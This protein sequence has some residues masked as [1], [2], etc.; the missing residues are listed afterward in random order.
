MTT[1]FKILNVLLPIF[2]FELID[3]LSILYVTLIMV[4]FGDT[5]STIVNGLFM[6]TD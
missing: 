3:K 4:C 6:N 1:I 2:P 5:V